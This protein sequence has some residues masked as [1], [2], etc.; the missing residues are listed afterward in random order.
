MF[1]RK[2]SLGLLTLAC[3]SAWSFGAASADTTS[4]ELGS[5]LN[6]PGGKEIT[7]RD[8]AGAIKTASLAKRPTS[9]TDPLVGATNLCVA[10]T[11]TGAFP[12]ARSACDLAVEIS[13]REDALSPGRL[14]SG[15]ASSRALSNRG[16]L[17]ALIGDSTGAASDFRAA[18]KVANAW[19]AARRNLAHLESSPAHR[20]ALA[21]GAAD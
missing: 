16:V 2:G 4:F 10:Y 19:P 5:Y 13:R 1:T 17:R 7:A 15:T 20:V 21:E 9:A 18:A 14:P 3:A 11:A 8:Y 12:E 6:Y